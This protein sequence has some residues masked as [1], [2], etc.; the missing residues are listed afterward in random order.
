MFNLQPFH[1]KKSDMKKVRKSRGFF[2]I[3]IRREKNLYKFK[4]MSFPNNCD[5]F[6]FSYGKDTNSFYKFINIYSQLNSIA[7]IFNF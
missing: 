3:F 7:I 5:V 4:L 2:W 1:V 6:L